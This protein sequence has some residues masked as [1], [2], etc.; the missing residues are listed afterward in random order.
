[1]GCSFIFHLDDEY[2]IDAMKLGNKA[3][4]IN[5]ATT[6]NEAN[7]YPCVWSV[8]GDH[9][10]G[11]F[12]KGVIQPGTELTFDY[13]RDAEFMLKNHQLGDK[14]NQFLAKRRLTTS[15]RKTGE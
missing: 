13:G 3:K 15:S 9:Y 11:I 4:F 6:D 10:M 7:C 14:Y 1:M 12:A 8:N 2:C 5:C